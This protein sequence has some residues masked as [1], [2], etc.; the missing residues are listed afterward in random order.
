MHLIDL[1]EYRNRETATVLRGLEALAEDG[2]LA[3]V[4][5][6]YQFRDGSERIV[7]TGAYRRRGEASRAGFLLQADA[8]ETD[9]CYG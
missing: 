4:A 9:S 6:V 3:G 5:T 1:A 8:D 2:E 7:C